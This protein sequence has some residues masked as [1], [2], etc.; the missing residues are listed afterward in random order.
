MINLRKENDIDFSYATLFVTG[1]T[2]N[3]QFKLGTPD[4]TSVGFFPS[5]Y[6][7]PEDKGIVLRFNYSEYRET[8]DIFRNIRN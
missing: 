1:E 4:F 6:F 7:K 2:Y 3:V 8:F 5:P